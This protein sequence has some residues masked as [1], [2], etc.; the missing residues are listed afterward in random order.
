MT[1][2]IVNPI[3]HNQHIT[4]SGNMSDDFR[5]AICIFDPDAYRLTVIWSRKPGSGSNY[6]PMANCLPLSANG[7][8]NGGWPYPEVDIDTRHIP[9]WNGLGA[10]YDTDNNKYVVVYKDKSTGQM[11]TKIGTHNSSTH[12]IDFNGSEITGP[13]GASVNNYTP[14]LAFD[15]VT[16]RVVC[17]MRDNSSNSNN[18]TAYVGT[19]SGNSISWGS[20]VDVS[21]EDLTPNGGLELLPLNDGGKMIAVW[22]PS[23]GGGIKAT[24]VTVS[25][26]SNTCT[27]GSTVTVVPTSQ[28]VEFNIKA[29]WDK[30]NNCVVVAWRNPS[31]TQ[32]HFK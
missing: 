24:L 29:A 9:D 23:S 22:K 2:N 13:S 25:N 31:E 10:C 11:Y 27:V 12:E 6:S 14:V 7:N 26:S 18:V 3:P 8:L 21:G 30:T 28:S 16:N 32:F 17:M 15:E 5:N 19:V 4:Q 1:T 20:Y